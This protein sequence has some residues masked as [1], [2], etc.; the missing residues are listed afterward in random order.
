MGGVNRP[1]V[2][3]VLPERGSFESVFSRLSKCL[4]DDIG[5]GRTPDSVGEV[6]YGAT[7]FEYTTRLHTYEQ[8]RSR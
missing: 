4:E 7:G 1:L 2:S 3:G 8:A 6:R 5:Q